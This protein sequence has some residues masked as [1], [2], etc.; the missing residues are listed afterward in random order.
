MSIS[1][2]L[3]NKFNAIPL[4]TPCQLF[5]ETDKFILIFKSISKGELSKPRK[6][7]YFKATV[8]KTV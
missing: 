2:N 1:P 6:I 8:I 7:I 5:A 3:F 4:K